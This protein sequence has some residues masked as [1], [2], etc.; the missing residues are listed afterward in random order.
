MSDEP[1]WK[2]RELRVVLADQGFVAQGALPVHDTAN[3]PYD[4]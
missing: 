4:R 3:I 1:R 2:E